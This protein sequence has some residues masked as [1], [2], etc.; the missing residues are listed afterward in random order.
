MI[1]RVWK[2]EETVHD[3][4]HTTSSVK[5]GGGSVIALACIAAKGTGSLVLIDDV[6][7]D[8]SSR[9][10]SEGFRAM[11]SAKCFK[12]HWTALHS[13]TIDTADGQ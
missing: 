9:M 10:N 8:K 4:K 12:T 7:A 2:R 5:H 6:T 1:R 13:W 11:F 3:P